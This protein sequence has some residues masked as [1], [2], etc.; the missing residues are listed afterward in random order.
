M[1]CPIDG[2]TMLV[3]LR[4]GVEIDFCPTCRGV[5]MDRGELTKLFE[6]EASAYG[7]PAKLPAEPGD[8]EPAAPVFEPPPTAVP[9]T[10]IPR[11]S[12]RRDQTSEGPWGDREEHSDDD[13]DD[14][15]DKHQ[16]RRSY[17]S[18]KRARYDDRDW[19]RRHSR[20]QIVDSFLRD[21]FDL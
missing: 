16:R 13:D 9:E 1:K 21:F 6:R 20:E 12:R 15:D 3:T 5:W 19:K 14:D 17:K 4:L 2:D 18:S 11:P 10:S 8:P 7:G